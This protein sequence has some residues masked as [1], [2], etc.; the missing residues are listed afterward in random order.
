MVKFLGLND[1]IQTIYTGMA[2]LVALNISFETNKVEKW[3]QAH[4][5]INFSYMSRFEKAIQVLPTSSRALLS[6][7][8][9]FFFFFYTTGKRK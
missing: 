4:N 7:L 8:A 9:L 3:K 6:V 2:V 5:E 1:G